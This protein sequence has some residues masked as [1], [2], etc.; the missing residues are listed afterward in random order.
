MRRCGIVRGTENDLLADTSLDNIDIYYSI[1]VKPLA[2]STLSV[3]GVCWTDP[4]MVVSFAFEYD[5]PN[6]IVKFKSDFR[7]CFCSYD[8]YNKYY[9]N[10][11]YSNNE[12]GTENFLC[13]PWLRFSDGV[14]GIAIPQLI[15]NILVHVPNVIV[16]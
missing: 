16:F 13:I 4:S 14:I 11:K 10:V 9:L 3:H 6:G 15:E 8:L 12:S 2:S 7:I 1:S 5:K